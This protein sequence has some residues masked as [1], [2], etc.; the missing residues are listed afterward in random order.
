MFGCYTYNTLKLKNAVYE[1][2]HT[3]Y[4]EIREKVGDVM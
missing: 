4:A 2:G 3:L 1:L